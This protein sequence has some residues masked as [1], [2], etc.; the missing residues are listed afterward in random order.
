VRYVQAQEQNDQFKT[1]VTR[2]LGE[3]F[4]DLL[5]YYNN[6]DTKAKKEFQGEQSVLYET[7]EAYT[8][9]REDYAEK[10]PLWAEYFG[11]DLQPTVMSRATNPDN[12]APVYSGTPN[13]RAK[14]SPSHGNKPTGYIPGGSPKPRYSPTPQ[15]NIQ[16]RITSMFS[17]QF[18]QA[19]GTKLSWEIT[20]LYSG[21][22]RLSSAAVGFLRNL[23]TRHPEWNKNIQDILS[24]NG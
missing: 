16:S 3:S 15:F 10:N 18:L 22:R 5:G 17:P 19:V 8:A 23:A 12:T 24:R 14:K 2:E 1:A 13:P 4:Y 20:S 6:L 21:N 11:F 7:I 9:L